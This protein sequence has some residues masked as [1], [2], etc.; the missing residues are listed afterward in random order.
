MQH[1]YARLRYMYATICH[2]VMPRWRHS[3]QSLTYTLTAG[4][5]IGFTFKRSR[6]ILACRFRTCTT[7]AYNA[8]PSLL[9]HHSSAG[10]C[11]IATFSTRLLHIC[12]QSNGPRLPRSTWFTRSDHIRRHNE[13]KDLPLGLAAPATPSTSTRI[14]R[15]IILVSPRR[16]G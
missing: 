5:P 8:L 1:V 7:G 3:T 16:S 13:F 10:P 9:H 4:L 14:L 2:I 15:N 11:V 6:V 12:G